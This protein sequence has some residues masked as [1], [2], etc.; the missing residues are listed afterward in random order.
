M[1]VKNLS[2]EEQLKLFQSRGMI[3]SN[4]DIKRNKL[5]NINYYRLKEFAAPLSTVKTIDGEK[6]RR[7]DGVK[8]SEIVIRYYQDKNLRIHLFHA[9]EKI[10]VSLK[11]QLS[12]VLGEKYGAFGYLRFS[13]WCNREEYCRHYLELK[14]S[15]FKRRLKQKLHRSNYED[16]R[17]QKNLNSEKLPTI[18]LAI[19]VLSFG[20]LISLLDLMSIK[21]LNSIAD[22][23]KCSHGELLSWLKCLHFI[24]NCCAHN[25]NVIDVK[26]KT[27]PKVREEWKEYLYRRNGRIFSNRIAITLLIIRNLIKE[28]NPS[29]RFDEIAKSLGSLAFEKD[30]RANLLGFNNMSAIR[31]NFPR[32]YYKKKSKTATKP[33]N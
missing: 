7:Y 33:P 27:T 12:A 17:N 30:E 13:S 10:E 15:E 2:F 32:K 22:H 23:Y 20:D 14:N 3:V 29:Y 26:L 4:D 9:I 6:V 5:S 31:A 28:I 1:T 16:L 24:R 18:W 11:T 21:N 8:F 25:S 19:D